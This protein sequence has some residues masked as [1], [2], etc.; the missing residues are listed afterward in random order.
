MRSVWWKCS[1]GHSWKAKISERAIEEKGCTVC[2][3]DYLTVFPKLAVMFYAA[4]KHIKVQFDTDKVIVDIHGAVQAIGLA[5]LVL[6]FVVGVV[7]T[8]GSFAD[9]KKPEHAV[10]L[11]IR[12]ALAK[13]GITYGMELMLALFN[14]VQGT[15]GTIMTAAGFTS[16]Q[17]TTLPQEMIDTIE[18][19]GFFESIPLWAVTLIGGLFITVMSFLLIMTVYGRFF[20][21]YMYTALAPIPLST[22]AGEPSQNVGKSFIK[23]YCAVCLEGAVIVLACIIFS[24]FASSPPVVD[25]NAAAVT[26]VW[27]YIGELL[28]NMLVLVGAVRM[29]DRIIREMMGL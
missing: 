11:F 25:P 3:K 21:L 12:F 19:C 1:L 8:C 16:A 18:S 17:Q 6:F 22:F 26:Q 7:K 29:S 23:S 28:F 24:L 4:M 15:I 13:A 14:I 9:V 10:K 20:K 5:L 2:E 27:S